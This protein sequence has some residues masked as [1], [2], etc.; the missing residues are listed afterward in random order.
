[1]ST[2]TLPLTPEKK[3][4]SQV[5][6]AALKERFRLNP[7]SDK[8]TY[9]LV[10]EADLPYK[11]GDSI[12]VYP[13]NDPHY[14]EKILATLNTSR[15]HLVQDREGNPHTLETFLQKKANLNRISKK[16]LQHKSSLLEALS[17]GNPEPS[18][19][20]AHLSP[21]PPRY[22][23]IAS[24][25]RHSPHEIH[26]TISVAEN[27]VEAPFPF[28]TCSH[29]LCHQAPLGDPSIPI[30]LQPSPYFF[31][32]DEASSKPLIMI[33]PGT[34]IAPFRGFLQERAA[35]KTS[36]PN[37]LFFGE[38]CQKTDFYYQNEWESLQTAGLLEVTCAFS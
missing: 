29:Y 20:C 36:S 19:F 38:R 10:L 26:L 14:V 18:S 11:V 9:H 1:M 30:F 35:S 34:G 12:G 32:P 28:G 24:S 3:H 16:I 7:G 6:F 21:I 25:P 8:E 17:H 13:E 23:S 27:P 31:L 37:W 15:K 4:S 5:F 2:E 22:Y 33:G